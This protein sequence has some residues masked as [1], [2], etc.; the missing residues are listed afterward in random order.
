MINNFGVE[1]DAVFGAVHDIRVFSVDLQ[2]FYIAL[3]D[4]VKC[5]FEDADFL[6][7]EFRV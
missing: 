2:L 4:L 1:E 3:W 6:Q 5:F 7:K